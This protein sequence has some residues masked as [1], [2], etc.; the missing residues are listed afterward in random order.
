[1]VPVWSNVGLVSRLIK[2]QGVYCPHH[3]TYKITPVHTHMYIIIQICQI[4]LLKTQVSQASTPSPAF[5]NYR[6]SLIKYRL[7]LVNQFSSPSQ[8][9]R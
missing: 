1:M 4:T 3:C 9:S 5:I 7:S 2:P 8:L 6:L